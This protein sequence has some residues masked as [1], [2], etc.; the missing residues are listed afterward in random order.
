MGTLE[1]V[2]VATLSFKAISSISV[3]YTTAPSSCIVGFVLGAMGSSDWSLNVGGCVLFQPVISAYDVV[4]ISLAVLH[5]IFW[6]AT[7]E[8]VLVFSI[9]PATPPVASTVFKS[10]VYVF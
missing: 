7:S 4:T 6:F 10:T 8:F 5:V 9:I 3:A 1:S 2:R